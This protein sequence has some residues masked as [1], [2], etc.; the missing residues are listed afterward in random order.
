MIYMNSPQN[1][2]SIETLNNPS[3][4][5]TESE[6]LGV[7][8]EYRLSFKAHVNKLYKKVSSAF[9]ANRRLRF[10]IPTSIVET[11]YFS[12]VHPYLL[13]GICAWGFS[14]AGNVNRIEML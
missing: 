12:I 9:G 10:F 5:V 3:V 14:G 2:P 1:L 4:K 7:I 6:I 8:I 13:Y 11:L